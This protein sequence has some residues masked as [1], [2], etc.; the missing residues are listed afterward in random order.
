[1]AE[2]ALKS[3][4][5]A[6]IAL[7][8]LFITLLLG[9][10]LLFKIEYLGAPYPRLIFYFIIALYSLTICYSLIFNRAR[11]LLLFGY[12]QLILD[13]ITE[14]TLIFITGGIESWFSF[15]LILTV[16]SSSIVLNKR[17]GYVIASLSSIFY[18]GLLDLQFYRMLPVGYEGV[19][20]EKQFLFNIFIHIISFY[21][22]AYL[23]GYPVLQS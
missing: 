20:N 13:V 2:N 10:S 16:L 18:G 21:I 15:T 7:R 1:M 11:N 9:S 17:A 5:K 22:T 4:I 12:L 19:M 6:L 3:R 8:A 14:I 23:G